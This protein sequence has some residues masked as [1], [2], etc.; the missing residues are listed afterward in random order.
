M[1]SRDEPGTGLQAALNYARHGWP[2]F[3]C[4]HGE[5]LPATRHGFQD[6]TADPE[7]I[8]RWWDSNP[9][10]NVAIAT[11]APGPDVLD[12][13][14]HGEHGNGFAAFNRLKREGLAD[15]P[16]AV[17]STPSG[18]FHI[19][20]AADPQR[21]QGNGKLAGQH[22]D[23]RGT[24][25]YVVAPPSTV[26]GR[27]YEV[28][29]H[30]TSTATVDFAAIRR[31]LDPPQAHPARPVRQKEALT[32]VGRLAGHVAKLQPGN[33]NDGLFWASR[34]AAEAGVLDAD[35]VEQLVEASLRSGIRGGEREARKTVLSALRG[36]GPD[37]TRER[38]AG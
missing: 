7:Q 16:L 2:V 23:F 3:P 9:G 25:G 15:G 14:N 34:R 24:G 12:V 21:P 10:R 27:R 17:V 13:D 31:L 37:P 26:G 28:V 35:A 20:F 33:R 5:K 36:R 19:Y 32:D 30:Q 11:G 6:A 29:S 38:E 8:T 1:T 4:V 18:G 22:I